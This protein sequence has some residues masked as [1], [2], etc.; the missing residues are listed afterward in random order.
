MHLKRR[1]YNWFSSFYDRFVRLH[2]GDRNEAMRDFII[3]VADLHNDFIVIDLCTGTGATALRAA[4]SG[5]RVIGIDFSKGMLQQ[6]ARKSMNSPAPSWVEA[7]ARALPVRPCTVDRVTCSY[8]MYE[9]SGTMRFD[10]MQEVTRILKPGG[11]F[12]MM[13]HLPPRQLLVKLLY[14]FRIYLLGSRGVRKFAG[15]EEKEL[16]RFLVRVGTVIS[17][18]GKTKVVFGYKEG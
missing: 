4:S 8:A 13:E 11:M 3:E 18:G 16:L 2:S 6:A 15:A 1:Y 14:F 17:P 5:V 7:D 12:L 10:V 9:L